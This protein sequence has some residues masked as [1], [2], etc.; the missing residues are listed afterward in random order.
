MC[1]VATDLAHYVDAKRTQE[2]EQMQQVA[3]PGDSDDTDPE[4]KPSDVPAESPEASTEAGESL[5]DQTPDSSDDKVSETQR[6]MD[7]A[8]KNMA[9]EPV[10]KVCYLTT[11]TEPL[12]PYHWSLCVK[13]SDTRASTL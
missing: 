9:A 5:Q 3:A 4:G 6:A 13:T 1:R 7:E 12:S 2:Q 8:M 10:D 11:P